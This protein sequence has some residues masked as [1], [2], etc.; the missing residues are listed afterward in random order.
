M[1]ELKDFA[2]SASYLTHPLVLIGY[3]LLLVFSIHKTLI[4]SGIIPTVSQQDGGFLVQ[5]L[6]QYGFLL[7]GMVILLGFGLQFFKT[8][9]ETVPSIDV[10]GVIE[11]LE[12]ANRNQVAILEQKHQQELEAWK[13]Q[14]T[15]AVTALVNLRGEKDTPLG[16]EE[17]VALLKQGKT[18]AAEGIFDSN[19]KC[20]IL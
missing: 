3:V 4:T 1:V 13:E 9:R 15:N 18:E 6:L 19:S 20:V 5:Q 2:K 7:A 10:K 14:A 12:S 11:T 17:A 16:I 8:H